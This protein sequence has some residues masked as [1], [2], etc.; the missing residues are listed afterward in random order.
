MPTNLSNNYR[1]YRRY[2]LSVKA[3]YQK[4]Q[5]RVYTGIVLSILTV[6]FFGFFAIRPT[7]VTISGLLKEIKD[8][9]EVVNQMD[10]KINNL[11]KAQTNYNQI[12]E[13]L[14]LVDQSLPQDPG[15]SV[16]IKQLEALTRLSSVNFESVR[17]EKTNLQGE[18]EKKENQE[19]TFSLVLSGNYQNL[20][21][22]LNSLDILRRVILVESFAF[23]S[24]MEEE[25]QILTLSINAKAYYLTKNQ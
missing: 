19:V 2:F 3:F 15:L 10:Q 20:K 17:F 8:K 5:A 18:T 21:N 1:Q 7:L 12:K 4:R 6:A 24:T 13:K 22:F 25:I 11:T 14:Y 9:K 23:R 16:L